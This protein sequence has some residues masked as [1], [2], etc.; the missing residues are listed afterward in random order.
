MS[1]IVAMGPRMWATFGNIL[2]FQAIFLF[3]GGGLGGYRAIQLSQAGL[4]RDQVIP[5]AGITIGTFL[6]A[7]LLWNL[8]GPLVSGNMLA[9]IP[10]GLLML[11]SVVLSLG[12]GLITIGIFYLF[13][14]EPQAYDTYR[15]GKSA[16]RQFSAPRGWHATAH[17]GPS[18]AMAY[19]QSTRDGSTGIFDSWTPVQVTE[20]KNGLAKI[21]AATGQAGW[22]DVRT[23]IEGGA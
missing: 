7:V 19:S 11:L 9:R 21:V 20:R 14:G 13:T 2:R 3:L 23:V 6:L 16:K 18:G 15:Q 17:I 5:V 12:T 1:K 8:K 22:I 4:G 10:V